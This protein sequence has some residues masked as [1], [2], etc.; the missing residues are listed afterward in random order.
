GRKKRKAE[1]DEKDSDRQGSSGAETGSAG[2]SG[3][4]E[5]M[6][7]DMASM[8]ELLGGLPRPPQDGASSSAFAGGTEAL[9]GAFESLFQAHVE[10][11]VDLEAEKKKRR[12]RD[13]FL[14]RMWKGMKKL[15]KTLAPR[16][17]LSKVSREDAQEFSFFS[18]FG[19][20]GSNGPGADSNEATD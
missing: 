13:K 15:L 11:R 6:K 9:Q 19:N 8:R 20:K 16:S 2:P 1:S 4:F 7:D 12:W 18:G 17:K 14:V 5:R 3:P 10:L